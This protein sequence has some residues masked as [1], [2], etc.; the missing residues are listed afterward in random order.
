MKPILSL[1]TA[2]ENSK[3][4]IAATIV[5]ALVASTSLGVMKMVTEVAK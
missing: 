2:A 5:V 1:I 4:H 3:T